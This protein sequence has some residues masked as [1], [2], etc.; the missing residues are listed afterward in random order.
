[1]AVGRVTEMEGR[2]LGD[3]GPVGLPA[4]LMAMKPPLCGRVST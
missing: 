4:D 1:M 3:G 2:S